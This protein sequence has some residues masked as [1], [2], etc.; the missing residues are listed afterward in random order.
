MVK[1]GKVLWK[2][3]EGVHFDVNQWGILSLPKVIPSIKHWVLSQGTG[4]AI[5][6][7][8]HNPDYQESYK[9]IQKGK[10][11]Q[12]QSCEWFWGF[13]VVVVIY[14]MRVMFFPSKS[15]YWNT[16]GIWPKTI[17]YPTWKL[18]GS[19]LY[20]ENTPIYSWPVKLIR[21]RF[22]RIKGKWFDKSL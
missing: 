19:R 17:H 11:K 15:Y 6:I 2:V 20:G 7:R 9:W 8:Q 13:F 14:Y 3:P 21:G 1:V 22:E 5:L 12:I 18:L 16:I 4:G 10:G